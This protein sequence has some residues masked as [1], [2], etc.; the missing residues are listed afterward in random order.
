MRRS[1]L[2]FDAFMGIIGFIAL[3]VA[4]LGIVN[5]MVMSIIER[6]REIGILKSLG[7]QEPQIRL[8]F[9]VE[10]GTI[11]LIGSIGGLCLG[12]V[13]SR[14]A[15]FL[16]QQWMSR[17]EVPPMDMFHLPVWAGFAAVVFGI[18]VSVLAGL[19]PSARAARIDPVEALRH[20]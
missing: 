6:T 7:A 9:L 13:V 10:S 19:Y 4:A 1:F 8:L 3:F 2:I 5:T 11:G 16:T 12:W 14:V 20:E 18:V 15:S 17:Q